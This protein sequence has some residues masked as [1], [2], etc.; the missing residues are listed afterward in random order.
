[1]FDYLNFMFPGLSI[2]RYYLSL[3]N[4]TMKHSCIA[5]NFKNNFLSN[6][7]VSF[8]NQ[9]EINTITHVFFCTRVIFC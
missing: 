6:W 1:M 2:L 4:L 8:I 5:V 3:I 9:A 7:H